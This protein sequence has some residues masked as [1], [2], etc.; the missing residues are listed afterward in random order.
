MA[1]RDRAGHRLTASP[2]AGAAYNRGIELLLQLQRGAV[3]EFAS[4]VA[5]DPG[6]AL[7]HATLAVVGREFNA[8]VDIAARL[9]AA[10]RH[11]PAATAR[12]RDQVAAIDAHVRGDRSALP[13]HLRSHPDDALVLSLAVPTI[14][15]AGV[16]EVPADGW[17]LVEACT[18]AA[19]RDWFHLGLLAFTR[20]EQGR[21]DEAYAL[22][23][24]ALALQPAAG[25]AA[26]AR[27]HVHYET[28]DHRAGLRWIDDWILR[29]GAATDNL[30]HYA[31]HAALHELSE[32]DFAAVSRRFER[33]LDRHAVTGCRSLVDAGSL[34]WRWS[35]TP[36][37]ADVPDPV[38]HTAFPVDT[39]LRP[40]TAFVATHAVVFLLA[41]D[42]LDG[43][44]RLRGYAADAADPVMREVVVPL[45]DA[46]AQLLRGRP[47][48]CADRLG[49]LAP[50]VWRVGGS[51]AQREVVEETRIVALL[52]A[53]R[54]DEAR[55]LIDRRLDR[56]TC[57]RDRWF[58]D[59]AG[60]G[61]SRG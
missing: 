40:Q 13:R 50:Q 7:A 51:D 29:D 3:E 10:R 48:A 44:L 19:G 28:G 17:E 58:R 5:L 61:L 24:S 49:A 42:D 1:C 37:A 23:T 57:V 32:G 45:A 20:Q 9:G 14:A 18:S 46:V 54:F 8:P 22:A 52:R 15:F 59:A 16:T 31:W 53:E 2:E 30:S 26:H 6:F 56:R 36:H 4:A 39:L 27:A 12:E 21:F 35:I 33:Q 43:L 38:A 25:H 41:S 60:A 55:A 11:A 34:L 47:A